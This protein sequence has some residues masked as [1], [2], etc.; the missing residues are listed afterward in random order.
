[1][2]HENQRSITR[3]IIGLCCLSV[4]L[5]VSVYLQKLECLALNFE[6]KQVNSFSLAH[7]FNDK[8]MP[9][10]KDPAFIC[11]SLIYKYGYLNNF[12]TIS[13]AQHNC[14]DHYSSYKDLGRSRCVV[15]ELN[16]IIMD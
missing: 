2:P 4:C 16:D 12:K 6:A 1:M 3:S 10:Q 13:M 11:F 8:L 7:I 5:S 14:K 9:L 15:F